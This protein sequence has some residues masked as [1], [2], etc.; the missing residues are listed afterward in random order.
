MIIYGPD[1]EDNSDAKQDIDSIAQPICF[2]CTKKHK[3]DLPSQVVQSLEIQ[4]FKLGSNAFLLNSYTSYILLFYLL[5]LFKVSL[6]YPPCYF[7]YIVYS[8]LYL[9]SFPFLTWLLSLLEPVDL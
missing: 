6:V 3:G 7:S 4:N 9:T 5:A 2:H 1:Y 8:E